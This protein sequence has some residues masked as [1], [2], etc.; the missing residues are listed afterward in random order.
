[1][2]LKAYN[3]ALIEDREKTYLTAA[4]AAG[5][6]ALTV[7]AINADVGSNS[8]WAD[9]TYI[10]LGEIG[11]PTA[12]VLQMAATA[13]DGTSLTIDQLGAGGARFAHSIGEPV[14][15]I[16][17]I[18]VEFNQNSTNTTSGVTVLATQLIQ[19]DEEY[20]RYEDTTN[21]TGYG[22]VRWNNQTSSTFSIYSDGVN[23]EASGEGSSYDPRTLW[24]LR[25]RIRVLLDED[26]PTSKL[27]DDMVRDAMNDKQRD[28]GH[29]R[30]WSF[31]EGER[32][33]SIVA[34]QFAYDIPITV[35]K[36]YQVMF[37]TQPLIYVNYETWKQLHWDSNS[38][39]DSPSHYTI[40]NRQLLIYP[41]PS[42]ASSTT[43]I[44]DAAGISATATS[45]TVDATSG[46]NRG[47]Y[48]RFIIDSEVI[49]ATAS[50]STTFTGLLRGREGTTAA[51]HA[52]DATITERDIVYS[53]HVEPTDL[54]DT[55]DRTAIPE[56]DVISYGAAVDLAPIAGKQEL[57]TSFKQIYDQKFK[58][59]ETKY[60]TK[61]TSQ[62][63]VVKS[64]DEKFSSSRLIRNP[65]LYPSSITGT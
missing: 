10:I 27:S 15:R 48:F 53:T 25:K 65:N 40:W 33:F 30:L 37:D 3:R 21:T 59:L 7:A 26:R 41:R 38:S 24:R 19:P 56:A 54:L 45:V 28:I 55:Q 5:G 23:Y 34:N 31:L 13:S 9:N 39:S 61:Q 43:A 52:D 11:S 12:E 32:S 64:A 2:I 16:N 57:I 4:V 18:R 6:T 58:E 29:S 17:Y 60:A 63:G 14:Y 44:N 50:T 47:D 35:Q 49:Y 36:I 8:T 46:F 1:M 42:T 51:T 20:T 62:F 22:F